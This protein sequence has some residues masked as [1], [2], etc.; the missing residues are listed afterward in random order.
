[1]TD[2]TP[3]A[4]KIPLVTLQTRY[5]EFVVPE[6]NDII[7]NSLREYGE[8]AQAELD[9]LCDFI[10]IGDV[11]VDGGAC[12]GTHSRAFSVKTGPLGKVICFEPAD[13]NWA[14]LVHNVE[15]GVNKN[16]EI[17][18][19]ALGPEEGL[20]KTLSESLNNSGATRV[21]LGEANSKVR[22]V[23][24]DD[25]V[26]S[27]VNFIKLDLE[28][29]EKSALIGASRILSSDRPTVF[30]EILDID[31]GAPLFQYMKSFGYNCYGVNSSAFHRNNFRRS[32]IDIFHGGT[33]CGLLFLHSDRVQDFVTIVEAHALP[34]I[35]TFDDLVVLLLQ[36]P[37]YTAETLARQRVA[38]K[39]SMPVSR[40]KFDNALKEIAQTKEALAN[41]SDE[42]SRLHKALNEKRRE[43][44]QFQE[45]L[46]NSS[47]ELA[48]LRTAFNE[49][50]RE[51]DQFQEALS[52]KTTTLAK[53]RDTLSARSAE[54]VEAKEALSALTIDL[55]DA[56]NA[57]SLL[58]TEMLRHREASDEYATKL[59]NKLHELTPLLSQ[60]QSE[61]PDILRLAKRV[62]AFPFGIYFR[63]KSRHRRS[64]RRLLQSPNISSIASEGINEFQELLN[65]FI[66]SLSV[67]NF[68]KFSSNV[69]Q[70][71]SYRSKVVQAIS[72]ISERVVLS[73]MPEEIEQVL[74]GD[75][76]SS[77]LDEC[78]HN[79]I[80][81]ISH[82]D[83]RKVT[84]G[85]QMCVQIE[86]ANAVSSNIDYLNI[87]PLRTSNALLP[88]TEVQ[89]ATFRLVLNGECIGVARYDE[90]LSALSQRRFTAQKFHF[91]IHHLLGHAPEAVA[92]LVEVAGDGKCYFWLHDFFSACRS[93][94][95]LRNNLNFCGGPDVLSQGCQICAFGSSRL[96]HTER[97][98]AF[99]N[100]LK[101]TVLAPSHVAS[102]T[103]S[104]VC[105]YKVHKIIVKPHATLTAAPR[106]AP[107][108]VLA[109]DTVGPIRI[110][111]IG[112]ATYHKGWPAFLK[113]VAAK[114]A[115]DDLE[116]H[117][118]GKSDVP[119]TIEKHYVDALASKT[120]DMMT[121]ALTTAGI[122][123]VIH[124]APWPETF[125]LTTVE[126]LRSHAYVVTHPASGNVA[127]LVYETGRG[128]VLEN[129]GELVEW[130]GS[131]EFV[132]VVRETRERRRKE[133]LKL[134]YS[135]MSVSTIL[136]GALQ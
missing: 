100:T 46:V 68:D 27:P 136:A 36:Q 85:T 21:V 35:V 66:A 34:Q 40:G 9:V 112:A 33:E 61:S 58:S 7:A 118:F 127:D 117:Y 52:N 102:R 134:Q 69:A 132:A 65:S 93:Y 25:E 99:F 75:A 5:G 114:T 70:P 59:M 49:Q 45:V 72:S 39:F 62:R 1:M 38:Q 96:V 87:H 22:M 37:Q 50:R 81:S 71:E 2:F 106:T 79:I 54:L 111:F 120:Q 44:A 133:L 47:D 80:I 123:L 42:L 109:D 18:P 113:L 43:A 29:L 90:I 3:D 84:G 97:F 86:C 103:W 67:S 78:R 121:R 56:R 129:E 20:V 135:D 14:I 107:L 41:S 76:I 88:N 92:R 64:T 4:L 8:W 53:T 73:P 31:T 48:Q 23:R 98:R 26:K 128:K 30:T 125:S 104:Q 28:G 15:K 24:L 60:W 51:A 77:K 110:A 122:D 12:F 126:A 108:Q 10:S 101:V 124:M 13:E 11:V 115:A 105:D 17:R 119:D 63:L 116:F 57:L 74:D 6:G 32:A 131:E 55:A 16:I 94:T 89:S 95:L 91:V 83:Y 130:I 19:F 82:D